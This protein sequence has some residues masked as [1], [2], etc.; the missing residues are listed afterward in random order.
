MIT[1]DPRIAHQQPID[2]VIAAL[3]TDGQG[4]QSEVSARD[5]STTGL[6]S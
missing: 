4:G 5:V 2:A 6:T 3:A 1:F